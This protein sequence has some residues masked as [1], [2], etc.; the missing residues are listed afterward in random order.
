MPR[1]IVSK[2]DKYAYLCTF[3]AYKYTIFLK[4]KI[5]ALIWRVFPYHLQAWLFLAAHLPVVLSEQEPMITSWCFHSS[6]HLR[7]HFQPPQLLSHN[8]VNAYERSE[9]KKTNF[10][11]NHPVQSVRQ[12]NHR[13]RRIWHDFELWS[14]VWMSSKKK[15]QVVVYADQDEF[16]FSANEHEKINSLQHKMKLTRYFIQKTTMKFKW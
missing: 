3:L 12:F 7:Y 15:L 8:P 13:S 14:T 16:K 6:S 1:C 4:I 11:P 10:G 5:I 9:Y 2:I